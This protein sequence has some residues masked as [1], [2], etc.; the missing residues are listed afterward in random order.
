[1]TSETDFSVRERTYSITEVER[2]SGLAAHTLRWYERLGLIDEVPR[3][4]GGRRA[5][6]EYHLGWLGF[7]ADMRAT[8]M[9]VADLCCYVELLRRGEETAPERLRMLERYRSELARQAA[10]L[11]V[12]ISFLDR[13][14][15]DHRE[16]PHA[17]LN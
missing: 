14:V 5:Y 16:L 15:A 12:N 2:L 10:E 6:S 7:L 8:R 3:G 9:S 17:E 1:M 4:P 13:K 11:A